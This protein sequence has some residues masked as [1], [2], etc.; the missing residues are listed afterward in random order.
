MTTRIVILAAGHGKRMGGGIPKALARVHGKTILSWILGAVADSG[1]DPSP[2]I[3]IGSGADQVKAAMG[4]SYT[5]VLQA[6]QRGTGHAVHCTEPVLRDADAVLVLY[7]DTPG[8]R[9]SSIRAIADRHHATQSVLTIATARVQDFEDWRQTFRSLGRVIRDA[10]G[11]VV[12]IAEAH[13]ATTED[14][15]VREINPALYCFNASWLWAHLPRLTTANAQGEYY[16]TDLIQMA[17]DEGCMI[18]T[19]FIA[20]EE[21]IGVNSP[22]DLAI[23]ERVLSAV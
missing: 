15:A 20:P 18:E 14:L 21:S 12:R 19:A 5:Y 1:V 9:A 2:V 22:E 10:A 6:E 11:N 23:A 4:A 16:L 8:I 7:G 13:D 3:V 17:I